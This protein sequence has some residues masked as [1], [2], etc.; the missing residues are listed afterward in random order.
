MQ[1]EKGEGRNTRRVVRNGWEGE[2]RDWEGWRRG[3]ERRG[4]ERRVIREYL[5]EASVCVRVSTSACANISCL[6]L[7]SRA[8]SSTNPK[9]V[10][11]SHKYSE[12]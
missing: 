2:G 4:E 10:I 12:I 9:T 11:L 8:L 1:C 3:E 5:L 7:S 6:S